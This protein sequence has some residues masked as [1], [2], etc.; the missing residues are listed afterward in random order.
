LTAPQSWKPCAPAPAALGV[1]SEFC[2]FDFDVRWRFDR[3]SANG[4]LRWRNEFF[5]F[6]L[7]LSKGISP[8]I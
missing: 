4:F 3:L 1:V 8:T 5:P 2:E 6:A 7:S